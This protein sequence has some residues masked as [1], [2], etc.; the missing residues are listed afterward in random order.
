ML[1]EYSGHGVLRLTHGFYQHGKSKRVPLHWFKFATRPLHRITNHPTSRYFP[2]NLGGREPVE[3]F[4]KI[5]KILLKF[6]ATGPM[7]QRAYMSA[8]TEREELPLPYSGDC[9]CC[10]I[11]NIARLFRQFV[12]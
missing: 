4:I 2:H 9:H 3:I 8:K 5:R 1:R 11:C 12:L 10:D 6:Q 7:L